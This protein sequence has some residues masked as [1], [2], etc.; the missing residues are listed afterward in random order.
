MA[1]AGRHARAADGQFARHR[2][3]PAHGG[4]QH[5]TRTGQGLADGQVAAFRPAPST[6]EKVVAQTVASVEP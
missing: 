4:G 5:R 1:V 2:A 6:V 3:A